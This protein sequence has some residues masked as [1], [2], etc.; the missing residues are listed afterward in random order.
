MSDK[1]ICKTAVTERIGQVFV[2][3]LKSRTYSEAYRFAL[4]CPVH[5][6][7]V[8]SGEDRSEPP[9]KTKEEEKAEREEEN[10][11][12]RKI[13]KQKRLD[14]KKGVTKNA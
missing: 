4:D 3:D 1:C 12:N 10:K 5:G 7:K 13:R 2:P 11:R 6:I 9:P 14:R 8:V